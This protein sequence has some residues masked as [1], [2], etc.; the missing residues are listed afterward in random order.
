MKTIMILGD[1]GLVGKRLIEEFRSDYH[2]IGLSRSEGPF[3]HEHISFDLEKDEILHILV[4]NTPDYFISVTRGDFKAQRKCHKT[5]IDYARV[6]DIEVFFYSTANVF[7]GKSDGSRVE[8]DKVNAKS[9][10]GKC[11]IAI[12]TMMKDGK[13]NIIRLPFVIAK[14]SPRHKLLEDAVNGGDMVKVPHPANITAITTDQ[15]AEMQRYVIENNLKGVFHFAPKDVMLMKDLY[16]EIMGTDKYLEIEEIPE[17]YLAIL[18]TREDMPFDY[19][20]HQV[21]DA[22]KIEG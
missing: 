7:D 18:Q 13:Q 12:E 14:G 15:I 20:N 17:F 5:I 21:I 4:E 3:D 22:V 2:I 1:S 8:N 11:K 6:D 10:Y 19:T 9:D 16:A